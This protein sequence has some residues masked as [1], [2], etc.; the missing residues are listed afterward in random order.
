VVGAATQPGEFFSELFPW[1]VV[2]I[3]VTIVG[4]IVVTVLRRALRDNDGGGDDFTLQ[5]LRD[6][7]AQGH[8]SED[9]F[10]RARAA[11]L[12]RLR[13]SASENTSGDGPENAAD[14][15]S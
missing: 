11:M 7:R 5:G 10:Q 8:I 2:L 4:A 14:T 15:P 9:E 13:S 6:L 1:L 12:E 3:G